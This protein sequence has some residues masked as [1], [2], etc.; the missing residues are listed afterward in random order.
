MAHAFSNS[1]DFHFSKNVKMAQNCIKALLE[2]TVFPL[3]EAPSF[4]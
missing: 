1:L 2:I 4:Y 3:I